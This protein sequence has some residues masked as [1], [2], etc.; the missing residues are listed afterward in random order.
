MVDEV[1]NGIEKYGRRGRREEKRII[2]EKREERVVGLSGSYSRGSKWCSLHSAVC[3][4]DA[5]IKSIVSVTIT[6]SVM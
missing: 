1:D 3:T 6:V 5:L 2:E 4:A